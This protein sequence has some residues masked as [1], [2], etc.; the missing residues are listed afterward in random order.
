[1]LVIAHSRWRSKGP[2]ASASHVLCKTLTHVGVDLPKPFTR[3]PVAKVVR[4]PLKMSVEL[5][6][7]LRQ[8]LKADLAADHPIKFLPL[9]LERFLRYRYV[10]IVLL[11]SFAISYPKKLSFSP[12]C[13]R[14]ITRVLSRLIS[15]P[16][17]P[18]NFDSIQPLSFPS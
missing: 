8:W 5:I 4:P 6:N 12:C 9:S 1:V 10:E 17:Q 11:S 18:S 2:L 3:V 16:I 13:L 7:Q 15:S 14:L